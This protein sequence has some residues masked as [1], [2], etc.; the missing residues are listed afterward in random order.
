MPAPATNSGRHF[1]KLVTPRRLAPREYRELLSFG[2]GLTD[3]VKG[4]AGGDACIDFTRASPDS[5]RVKILD[6]RPAVMAFNGK[7]AAEAFFGSPARRIRTAVKH[8]R[9][10]QAIRRTFD[11][12]SRQRLLEHRRMASLAQPWR[13][14]H[15]TDR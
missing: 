14:N 2:I 10:D 7:K 1:T 8:C 6:L 12:R 13:N 15:L 11:K 5:V 9:G 4:Q 3:V